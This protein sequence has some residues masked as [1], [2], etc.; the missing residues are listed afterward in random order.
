MDEEDD[1]EMN[2]G[3]KMKRYRLGKLNKSKKLTNRDVDW[4]SLKI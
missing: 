3:D 2:R 1:T 4:V